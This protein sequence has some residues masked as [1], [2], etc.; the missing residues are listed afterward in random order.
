MKV[1]ELSDI[2]KDIIKKIM[3]EDKCTRTDAINKLIF[4]INYLNKL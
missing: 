1:N 3:Y 4:E 2:L